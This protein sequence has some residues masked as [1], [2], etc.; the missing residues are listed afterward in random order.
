MKKVVA[1]GLAM[2]ACAV[3]ATTRE[4]RDGKYWIDVPK[5]E[6]DSLTAEDVAVLVPASGAQPELWKIGEGTLNMAT[7]AAT[8]AFVDY[9]AGIYVTNGLMAAL[10]A[11][12][13]PK[14][15]LLIFR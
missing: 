1:V 14:G 9:N 12:V 13:A 6:T 11:D 4:L 5:G 10:Y 2:T 8:E 15:M 3:A 7:N